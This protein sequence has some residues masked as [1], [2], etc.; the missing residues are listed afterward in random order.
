MTE[1]PHNERATD[2]GA[3]CRV[4]RICSLGWDWFEKRQIFERAI[5]VA[6]LYGTISIVH[7]AMDFAVSHGER[8]GVD[9]AAIIAAVGAPYLALQSVAAAFLLKGKS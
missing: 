5:S 6:I 4:A 1:R 3:L 2:R 9:A 8:S 7:W